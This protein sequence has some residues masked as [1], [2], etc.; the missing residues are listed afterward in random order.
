MRKKLLI[1][2]VM[3]LAG[4]F[5][6]SPELPAQ[7]CSCAATPL[8]NPLDFS[9]LKNRKW[10]FEL[11]FK[12]HA[13]NDLVEG[14]QK[15]EDDTARQ[16]TAQFM[17]FDVRYALM[18]NL[19][20][21]A[22]FSVGRQYR[23]IGISQSEPVSTRGIGDS[24]LI[25]QY[26]PLSYSATNTTE[27]SLGAGVKIPLGENNVRVG[28]RASEDM[29]PGTGSWDFLGWGFVA[30]QIPLWRWS[31]LFTG[32]S[33]RL[34]GANE[35]GYSFGNE[36]TVSLGARTQV[37]NG[38]LLSLYGRYRWAGSDQRFDAPLPNTG[39]HWIYV[40]P[41]VSLNI[42]RD[43]GIKTEIE[44]PVYRNLNGF[45]QFTSTFLVS[46]SLFFQH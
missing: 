44:L 14:T 46:V 18:S 36:I 9:T 29:Q 30:R 23:E 25:V 26:S 21:R 32:V 4:L 40:V 45:R 35:S 1:L 24:M 17:L 31:E 39:G 42:T 13:M 3:T 19:T 8:F 33:A 20:I 15:V 41:S 34:N 7:T 27:V 43:M 28:V 38:L 11:T 5:I 6:V 16:R 12:Y 22:V 10:H 2:G 37:A